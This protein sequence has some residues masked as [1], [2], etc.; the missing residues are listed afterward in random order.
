[1]RSVWWDIL[2]LVIGIALEP[3]LTRVFNVIVFWIF[4]SRNR[5][6]GKTWRTTWSFKEPDKKGSY[7]D[8]VDLKQI[9]PYI[10]ARGKDLEHDYEIRAKL[11]K[12]GYI[13]GTWKDIRKETDWHG[14]LQLLISPDGH[15]MVGKWVGNDLGKVRSGDWRWE[16]I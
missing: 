4:N 6:L 12:T 3:I 2:L 13:D 9:G 14:C 10:R 1:M 16:R 7:T 8:I 11:L 15:E 5:V